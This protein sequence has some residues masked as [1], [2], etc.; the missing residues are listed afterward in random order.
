L[1]GGPSPVLNLCL[2]L[3]ITNILPVGSKHKLEMN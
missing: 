2:P 1:P 3:G